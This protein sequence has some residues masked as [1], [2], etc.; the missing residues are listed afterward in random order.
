MATQDEIIEAIGIRL[1]AA[2]ER[3]RT[4]DTATCKAAYDELKKDPL[5]SKAIAKMETDIII[6]TLLQ[7]APITGPHKMTLGVSE[8]ANDKWNRGDKMGALSTYSASI[9]VGLASL[10]PVIPAGDAMIELLRKGGVDIEASPLRKAIDAATGA[11]AACKN[12]HAIVATEMDKPGYS[13]DALR[14][15]LADMDPSEVVALDRVLKRLVVSLEA[16]Q[17]EAAPSV[18]NAKLR[19][20]SA[21]LRPY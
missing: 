8:Q 18:P 2:L 6:D 16:V 5:F 3:V 20:E 11:K 21:G 15:N 1:E 19:G 4:S 17:P 9:A 14:S 13:R 7:R 12:L 10:V